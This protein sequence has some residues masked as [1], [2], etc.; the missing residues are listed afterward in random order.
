MHHWAFDNGLFTID[1]DYKIVIY[2][3]IKDDEN[4]NDIYSFEG[5]KINLPEKLDLWPDELY[6]SKHGEIHGFKQ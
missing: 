2:E 4:F 1:N 3:K 5:L 6:L